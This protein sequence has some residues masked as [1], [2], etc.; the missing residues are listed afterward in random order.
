M[1]CAL[2][3]NLGNEV[4]HT[5]RDFEFRRNRHVDDA[6]GSD[7]GDGVVLGAET[8]V[9]AGDVVEDDGVALLG[10]SFLA[11]VLDEVLGF[12]GEA[13][14]HLVGKFVG[15]EFGEDVGCRFEFE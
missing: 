8:D 13:D 9:G 12:G 3:A 5:L 7:D 15:A 11:G 14:K 4:E 1:A 10:A 6:V 2:L